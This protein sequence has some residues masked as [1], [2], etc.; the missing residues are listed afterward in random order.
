VRYPYGASVEDAKQK[1][2]Y[3][4]YY[5]KNHTLFLDILILLE[6]V[7]VVVFGRGAR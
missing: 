3:D 4:L 6:T 1:L 2:Q 7:K 5:V